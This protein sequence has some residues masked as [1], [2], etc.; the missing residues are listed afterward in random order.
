[1]GTFTGVDRNLVLRDKLKTVGYECLCL[2]IGEAQGAS[3]LVTT[4]IQAHIQRSNAG[5]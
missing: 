2:A 3:I 4:D 1:M 5:T